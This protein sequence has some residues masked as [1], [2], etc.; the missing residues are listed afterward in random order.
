MP[1]ARPILAAMT[2]DV[3]SLAGRMLIAMPGIGDPRF[4][5]AVILICAH[6]EEHAMGLTVN[7]PVDGLTVPSLLG[8]LGVQSS[9]NLPD[10]LVLFGGPVERE[11]GFVLHT[12]D[13]ITPE[14]TI[15]VTKGVGMTATREVLEAMADL[16]LRPRRSVLALG[17]AG[18]E[19][20]QLED[21]LKQNVWLTCDPDEAL[22]FGGDHEHKWGTALAKIGVAA[23]RLS[24]LSG[25]A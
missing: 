23:D 18:W 11:R 9:I 21:E 20:G 15:P 5:R 3:D 10:D 6:N 14:S 25:R 17:Y 13:Y 19:G 8:R 12:D 2:Y 16:A 7:R 24:T 22:L 1:P 4:E